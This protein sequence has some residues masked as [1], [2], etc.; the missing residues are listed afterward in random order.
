M[1]AVVS[2]TVR[3]NLRSRAVMERIGLS[4]AGE[5][6]SRGV[7]EGSGGMREDAP[8]S[9]YTLLRGRESRDI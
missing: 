9:V 6:Q 4:Y 2:C 8:Y 3:H 7:V 5:I 1:E